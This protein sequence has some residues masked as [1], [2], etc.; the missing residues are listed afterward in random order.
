MVSDNYFLFH[1]DISLIVFGFDKS[2]VI[3]AYV[4]E[5]SYEHLPLPLKPLVALKDNYGIDRSEGVLELNEEGCGL[6]EMWLSSREI[7]M[8]RNNLDKKLDLAELMF[9]AHACSFTDC[10]WLCKTSDIDLEWNDV[11]LYDSNNVGSYQVVTTDKQKFYKGANATLGGQLEKFW[12]CETR[13]NTQ[14]IKLC[15]RVKKTMGILAAR[16]FW[17]FQIYKALGVD[18]VPYELFFNSQND[19]VGCKCEAFTSEN[20]ELITASDLLEEQHLI[21]S[22]TDAYEDVT[23]CAV[24][25][26]ADEAE[27]KRFLSAQIMVDYLITNRD[28]H[29]GNFGFLRDPDTLRIVKPAPI[30]DS[31]SS[32]QLEDELPEGVEETTINGCYKTEKECLDH[33]PD[34]NAVDLSKVPTDLSWLSQLDLE[35]TDARKECIAD[36]FHKK[37]QYLQK[38]QKAH[39][40]TVPSKINI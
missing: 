34:W 11:K 35:L 9:E 30:F 6:L 10:Y 40:N 12:Y 26:G 18:A 4:Q 1:K 19:V 39:L 29:L 32:E 3:S 8:I 7:P 36:L 21:A 25:Y 23:R 37:L 16:E 33:I 2:D 13:H 20:L 15:K 27:V 24:A 17:A 22:D 5:S 14:T 31:G 28:R 38:L